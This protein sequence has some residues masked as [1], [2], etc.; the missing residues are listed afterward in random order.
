MDETRVRPDGL[1]EELVAEYLDRLRRGERPSIADFVARR[2]DLADQIREIFPALAL[3]EEFKPAW[4]EPSGSV[5]PAAVPGLSTPLS[6]LGDFRIL[7]EVGRGGMGVV[8]EAEQESLGRRVA[9]KVLGPNLLSD[10]KILER[11]HRE[12]RAAARL[13]H[14]NIVPVFGVGE[15][16]GVH[17]YVMQ[18]IPGQGLDQVLREVKRAQDGQAP[19]PG[20]APHRPSVERPPSPAVTQLAQSLLS[21][22]FA[23][24]CLDAPGPMTAKP[25]PGGSDSTVVLTEKLGMDATEGIAVAPAEPPGVAAVGTSSSPSAVLPGGGV[26]STVE[27]RR[28]PYHLSV[29]R[30]GQQA[31]QALAYAHLRGIVHRD[32]KPS[33]LLLDTSGIVWVT[34]FG[35][36]K[37]DDDALTNSG[38][39]VGTVRY[40]A[41]ER[42]RGEADPRADVYA[43]GLTLYELLTLRPAFE[44][45]DRLQLIESIKSREPKRP[46]AI[47]AHIPRDLETIVLKAID[48]EP[49]R[50]YQTATEL[51][52]DLRRFVE[53]QPILARQSSILEQVLRWHRRHKVVAAL[54][55][56]LLVLLTGGLTIMTLLYRDADR[57]RSRA[58]A[59]FRSAWT[60]VDDYLTKVSQERILDVPGLQPLRKE[61]VETALGYY[62]EFIKQHENDPDLRSELADAYERVGMI[63]DLIGSRPEAMSAHQEALNLRLTLVSRHPAILK[64]RQAAAKS[65]DNIGNLLRVTDRAEE[66]ERAHRQAIEI[67]ESL[68]RDHADAVPFQQD[69]AR[70]YNNL[71]VLQKAT[72]RT[73][74]AEQSYRRSIGF[75]QPL[76]LRL[77]DPEI[78]HF[79]QALAQNYTNLGNL[80]GES[81]QMADALEWY[82][83]ALPIFEKLTDEHPTVVGFSRDLGKTRGNV[84]TLHH[85]AGR[86]A[87][88]EASYRPAIKI[89]ERLARDHPAVLEFQQDLT[90]TYLNLG[91]LLQ[92]RSGEA[93]E[94]MLSY[95]QAIAILDRLTR[96]HP[97]VIA[98]QQE[99]ARGHS[100]LSEMQRST[101]RLQEATQTCRN[102]ITVQERLAR[103][104]PEIAEYQRDLSVT[105]INLG[106]L[107]KT[108]GEPAR[109]LSALHGSET[110]IESLSEPSALDLYDLACARA[111]SGA[112]LAANSSLQAPGESTQPQRFADRAIEALLRAIA[113]GWTD[114][115]RVEKDDDLASLRARKDF[116]GLLSKLRHK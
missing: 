40:M 18:L 87:E 74:E 79:L 43:M 73:S 50:R 105:Y 49:A 61:L 15:T 86:S 60:A 33:N 9:L 99:L 77:D 81:G 88:A 106:R 34:D 115:D 25:S 90:R 36:A 26:L 53:D 55:W 46:R 69:L 32:I 51:A 37:A 3:V 19:R 97:E 71:G 30:I 89:Q 29:A 13:H 84:G 44:S 22:R 108:T 116:Q 57:E 27:S 92:T 72:G 67:L 70:S 41:P 56:T 95:Q 63:T 102:A 68:V 104:H 65:L 62:R 107:L 82:Q 64:H 93:R 14:T 54:V 78:T 23:A 109:A 21:G 98:F 20:E 85:L 5:T 31:G 110:L 7:R 80:K 94:A 4:G 52:D 111:L 113:A 101:G 96:D 1:P 48:K 112:L 10:P 76:S 91:E 24:G 42:F 100:G 12:A 66:A 39:V 59:N 2:P 114:V 45:R 28:R 17:Y 103:E 83:K 16:Q 6:R 58:E 11:F 47:D 35:L 75:L 38:D 8:Y